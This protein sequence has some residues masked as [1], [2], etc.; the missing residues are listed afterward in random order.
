MN[1]LP[2]AVDLPESLRFL[3][4]GWWIVH[5][6]AILV[7]YLIGFAVGLRRAKAKPSAP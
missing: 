1:V 7:V 5:I 6:I 2:L 3:N 4:V